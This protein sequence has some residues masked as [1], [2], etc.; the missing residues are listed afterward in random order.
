VIDVETGTLCFAE[1]KLGLSLYDWQAEAVL[2]LEYATGENGTMQR[3]AVAAPNGSGKDD[4]IIAVASYWW[5][6]MH[7]RGKVVITSKS[8]TQLSL[9]TVPSLDRF[10]PKFGWEKPVR[11]PR[12]T[13]RTP[14]GGFLVA[15]VSN[16][17]DRVE[18]FHKEDDIDGPL[19]Q[20][21]NEGK[22]VT[23]DIYGGLA[24]HTVNA[25]L[26]VSST[27]LMM[28]SFFDACTKHRAM[29][30]VIQAGLLDCP[31]IPPAKIEEIIATYGPNHPMT[32]SILHGEFMEQA[33]ADSFCVPLSGLIGC[34]ESPPKPMRG[35]KAAFCDFADG[36]AEN[37]ICYRDGNVYTIEDAW[38]EKN[39]DAVVGKFIYHFNRLQLT[40]DR[41]YGDAA[42]KPILDKLAAAGWPINRINFGKKD[43]SGVYKS[44]SAKAWIEG[45][46]KIKN[47]EIVIPGDDHVLHAQ[48]T[49]RKRSFNNEGKLT[50]EDKA[51][52]LKERGIESP[53]RADTLMGAAAIQDADA[54]NPKPIFSVTG[55][56]EKVEGEQQRGF[57]AG[58]GVDAGGY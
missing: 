21:V 45:G 8:D 47:R 6:A 58:I 32:R 18:G 7:K 22:S 12:Y 55:W 28:G 23:E 33:D 16:E 27:G 43:P 53:D 4:R 57:L 35:F 34:I 2:P 19:L 3:I 11:S 41:I 9:Q 17:G 52:M 29:W 1:K 13:L 46:N 56:R 40:P 20:I 31:H 39:E 15:Y 36:R 14:T 42:A 49:T 24:R 26:W 30:T 10:W 5:L 37:V 50:I 51:I 25:K 54:L 38:R 44:W 48:L